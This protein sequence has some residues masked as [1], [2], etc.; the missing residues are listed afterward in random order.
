MATKEEDF[1][2]LR[3][4][5]PTRLLCFLKAGAGDYS[6]RVGSAI[7]CFYGACELKVVF[8]FLNGWKKLKEEFAT[9]AND[10]HFPFLRP[11]K[12]LLEDSHTHMY[13]LSPA[14]FLQHCRLD[15]LQG[16]R[17]DGQV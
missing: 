7:T 5:S 12:A 10:T 17:L 14:A 3:S 9:C 8:T 13:T 11:D 15:S 4:S 2:H 1:C 16:A 6:S